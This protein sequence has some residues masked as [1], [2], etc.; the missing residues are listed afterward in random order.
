MV[1][2]TKIKGR[3]FEEV[4]THEEADTIIPNQVL[5]SEHPRRETCVSSHDTDVLVL[6]ID[7]V[8]R[9]LLSPQTILKFVTDKRTK[10][11][12]IDVIKRV[13]VI[14]ARKCHGFVGLHNFSGADWGGKFIGISKKT[15]V[16]A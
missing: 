10:Y 3:D 9:G 16:N 8:S 1:Y 6:L 11:R 14:G 13:H 5:A 12:E 7:L 2:D 15:W 4:H